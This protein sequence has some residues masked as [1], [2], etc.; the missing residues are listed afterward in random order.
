MTKVYEH[1][2]SRGEV[3][4][5]TGQTMSRKDATAQ[6][7]TIAP[8]A[9][10]VPAA[11]RIATQHPEHAD[12]V[13]VPPFNLAVMPSTARDMGFTVSKVAASHSPA[14][15]SRPNPERV[16]RATIIRSPEANARP[17]AAA[18]L[19]ATQSPERMTAGKALAFLRGLPVE[20]TT[21][22][23]VARAPVDPK[24]ARLAEIEASTRSFNRANGYSVQPGRSPS[25][26]S[27]PASRLQRLAEMRLGALTI[28]M[29]QGEST[30]SRE[31]MNLQ[32][33]LMA[34]AT[35][36][37][38]LVQSLQ[39]VGIDPLSIMGGD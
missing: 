37:T 8:Y 3:L 5:A 21:P 29:E 32:Y 13:T 14:T 27:V 34:T 35:T 19:L 11:A 23:A 31:R 9:E 2:E 39:A 24:A 30:V 12:L 33:A 7:F 15:P 38:P 4:T 36:G 22:K 1:P 17:A 18:E 6:E 26:A 28:R 16:W 20:A 10:L 25:L